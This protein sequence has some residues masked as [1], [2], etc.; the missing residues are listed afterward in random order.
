MS[1]RWRSHLARGSVIASVVILLLAVVTPL[2]FYAFLNARVQSIGLNVLDENGRALDDVT[3]QGFILRPASLGYGYEEVFHARTVGGGLVVT[4]LSKLI[5][6][7]G[8]WIKLQ[9]ERMAAAS[10]PSILIFLS[11]LNSSGV[12]YEQSS[13]PIRTVDVISGASYSKE[14]VMNLSRAAFIPLSQVGLASRH[15]DKYSPESLPTP[16]YNANP[17]VG[18]VFVSSN[19]YPSSGRAHIPTAWMNV[20]S[21]SKAY[22]GLAGSLYSSSSTNFNVGFAIGANLPSGGGSVTLRDGSTAWTLSHDAS[23]LE[24]ISLASPGWAYIWLN[25]QVEGDL[26]QMW[27]YTQGGSGPTNTYSYVTGLVNVEVDSSNHVVG[28]ADYGQP[29]WVDQLQSNYSYSLYES[30][31]GTGSSTGNPYYKVYSDD[32]VRT[33][34][35]SY[36]TWT[37]VALPVGPILAW[38]SGGTLAIPPLVALSLVATVTGSDLSLIQAAVQFDAPVGTTVYLFVDVGATC[39]QPSNGLSGRIPLMGVRLTTG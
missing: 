7:S 2:S 1:A 17:Y 34:T 23:F 11:Y 38:A 32:L 31:S 30:R 37:N 27:Y 15:S 10:S 35:Q 4:N 28:G 21:G 26:F 25:A 18:W 6:V 20:P 9:G 16:P 3:V 36:T 29:P 39:Y 19:V 13:I 8:E 14:V 5:E 33:Y 22:G 24:G 12:Y